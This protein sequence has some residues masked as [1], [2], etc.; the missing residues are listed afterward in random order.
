MGIAPTPWRRAWLCFVLT[1]TATL[2]DFGNAASSRQLVGV[3]IL[4][5][6][7]HAAQ[8][9]LLREAWFQLPAVLTG[10]VLPRFFIAEAA[11]PAVRQALAVESTTHGDVEVL[12]GQAEAYD[13]VPHQ[14]VAMMRYF[15]GNPSVLWIIKTDDDVFLRADAIWRVLLDTARLYPK[16]A[17]IYT[18]WMVMTCVCV[19]AGVHTIHNTI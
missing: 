16:A 19:C 18:G 5:K 10:L 6:S 3:G 4:S 8:R 1:G 13:A 17:R 9:A 14:T 11:D 12:F 15:S 7:D 2:L